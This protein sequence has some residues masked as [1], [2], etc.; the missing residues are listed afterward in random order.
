MTSS[1]KTEW[2]YYGI[3]LLAPDSKGEV[4]YVMQAENLPASNI[5]PDQKCH[6]YVAISPHRHHN[7]HTEL[8]I[9]FQ[10]A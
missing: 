9:L 7:M 10:E 1:L 4:L 8:L 2:V 3:H 5:A 6:S